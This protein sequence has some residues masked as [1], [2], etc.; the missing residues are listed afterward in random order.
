VSGLRTRYYPKSRIGQGLVS[1]APWIDIVLLVAFF[2]HLES[3]LILQPGVVVELPKAPFRN[4]SRF[5]L[6]AVIMSVKGAQEGKS[7]EMVFFDDDRFLV[8]DEEQMQG[9]KEALAS[10]AEEHP[11][12]N[13]AI[14]SD[15]RVPHGTV[16]D[17]VN[18]ALEVGIQKVNVGTRPL[19]KK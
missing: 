10:R 8:D 12:D 2:I 4:G 7:Q 5:G 18:M 6:T 3:R 15:H 17:I 13:L 14:Q 1:I 19:S 11:D 9:L 16:V